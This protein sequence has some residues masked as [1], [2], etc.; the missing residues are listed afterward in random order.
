M[1]RDRAVP[2][3]AA[4]RLILV[5]RQNDPAGEPHKPAAFVF[6]TATGEQVVSIKYAWRV[7]CRRAKIEDL[8]FH[9]LR[10]EAGSRKADA[11]W[12]FHAVSAWLG[13]TSLKTTERYLNLTARQLHELNER[14]AI[15]LAK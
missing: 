6:G 2:I 9:D 14:P 3:S 5:R 15:A 8:H 7:A 12:P 4:L 10:H 1:V 13:H 11:G